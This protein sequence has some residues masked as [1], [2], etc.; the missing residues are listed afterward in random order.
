MGQGSASTL[1]T[2]L[3]S[4]AVAFSGDVSTFTDNVLELAGKLVIPNLG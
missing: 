4:D 1:L 2:G 3:V